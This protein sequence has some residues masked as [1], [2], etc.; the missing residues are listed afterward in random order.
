MSNY[1]KIVNHY[2]NCLAEH[3]DTFRGVDW[4][5]EE[6]TFKRY[7]VMLE[8]IKEKNE[9]VN[10]LD[11]GCGA[12][13]FYEYILQNGLSN[14]NY[15]GLDISEKFVELS[16]GKFPEANYYRV[17]IFETPDGIPNFDYIVMNGVLTEKRELSFDEMWQYAQ[18]LLINVF[19]K[20]HRG[21]AFNVMAKAVDWEREDLFHLP[22]D[23]LAGFL[24]KKL[25]RNFIIKNDYGLYEYT[26]YIYR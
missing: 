3:G 6:D 1:L 25:S 21:V 15:N 17:D 16:K 11:F 13:H 12:S 14:I 20:C 23:T 19:A 2:E 24:V 18:N 7:R 10:L 9:P 26:T 8:V 5:N 22:M 4:T